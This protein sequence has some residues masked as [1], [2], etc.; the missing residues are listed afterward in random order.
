[1]PRSRSAGGRRTVRVG[2][3]TS[4]I[5]KTG[6]LS[7][8]PGLVTFSGLSAFSP[9]ASFGQTRSTGGDFSSWAGRGT[10]RA[11]RRAS[12]DS[13]D[14]MV[15]FLPLL[16]SNLHRPALAGRPGERVEGVQRPHRLLGVGA[17]GR[18]LQHRPGK[19]I[20]HVG[21]LVL[22][23]GGVDLVRVAIAL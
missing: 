19:V 3:V 17:N 11:S 23:L 15:D 22:A 1:V 5:R 21:D 8:F 4:V 6:R 14:S 16:F 18:V 20:E 12:A 13:R 7:D 10:N 9:G 2:V